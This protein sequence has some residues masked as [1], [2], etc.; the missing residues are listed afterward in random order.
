MVSRELSSRKPIPAAPTR[1]QLDANDVFASLA[2]RLGAKYPHGR[3]RQVA[4][5][6]LDELL[7]II[8][9]QRRIG[10]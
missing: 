7:A 3:D 4:T 10:C 6:C 1:Q 9:E 5:K 2:R 8:G